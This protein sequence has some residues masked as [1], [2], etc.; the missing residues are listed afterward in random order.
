MNQCSVV[1]I[2]ANATTTIAACVTSA[3]QITTDVVVVTGTN[4]QDATGLLAKQAGAN[5]ITTEWL[6]YSANK[7][8]GN[9]HAKHQWIFWLDSDEV[10]PP[11][12]ATEIKQVLLNLNNNHCYAVNRLNFFG[13]SPI[14]FGAWNPDWQVRLFNKSNVL[15]NTQQLVHETLVIPKQTQ[16][17][18][19]DNCLWHY[20][21]PDYATYLQK[22]KK[23]AAQ[24]KQQQA[25]TRWLKVIFSPPARFI[26]ELFLKLGILDGFKGIQIAWAHAYYSYLKYRIRR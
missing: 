2:A 7:N 8:L 5:V 18:K 11:G 15:W 20:T 9:A 13:Q 26:S 23:Y 25:Q 1:I 14:R 4:T 12:L 17:I 19:L 21:T 22:M 10:I 3:L 24:Y 6:G 16:T